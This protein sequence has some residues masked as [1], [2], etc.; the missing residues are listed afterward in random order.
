MMMIKPSVEVTPK[1]NSNWL[2]SD[3]EKRPMTDLSEDLFWRQIDAVFVLKRCHIIFFVTNSLF[4][5]L[6]EVK[7]KMFWLFKDHDS[8]SR[9]FQGMDFSPNFRTFQDFQ[10]LW[11]P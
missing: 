11:Q 10:G 7:R 8:N 6:L 1:L 3:N 2:N 9:N 4:L 5:L